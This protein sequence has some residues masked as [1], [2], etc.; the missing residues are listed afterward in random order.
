M[1][2][3]V[4]RVDKPFCLERIHDRL[5]ML[6]RNAFPFCNIGHGL[7][8]ARGQSL[9]HG[10]HRRT[11]TQIL[12]ELF[13]QCFELIEASAD[14]CE[15]SQQQAF[16]RSHSGPALLLSPSVESWLCIGALRLNDNLIVIVID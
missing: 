9:H 11:Y 5:N 8:T 1:C 14:L 3:I 7:L 4:E 2:G 10:S 13:G 6:A 15:H 16:L 12:M